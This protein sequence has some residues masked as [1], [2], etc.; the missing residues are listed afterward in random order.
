MFSSLLLKKISS[1]VMNIP[2]DILL[3]RNDCASGS[4]HLKLFT[5]VVVVDAPAT[6][7]IEPVVPV[8]DAPASNRDSTSVLNDV[9]DATV[10]S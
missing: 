3:T 9:T 1:D 10:L 6:V 5:V 4:L 2:P 7:S 8:V